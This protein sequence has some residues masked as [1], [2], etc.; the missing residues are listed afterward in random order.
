MTEPRPTTNNVG[1]PVASD[2]DSL[3]LGTNGPILLQDYYLIE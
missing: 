3:T 2:D 1:I